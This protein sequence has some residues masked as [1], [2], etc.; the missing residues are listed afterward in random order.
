MPNVPAPGDNTEDS[1]ASE[2]APRSPPRAAPTHVFVVIDGLDECLP[3]EKSAIVSTFRALAS[4]DSQTPLGEEDESEA[5]PSALRCLFVSQEDA[6][7]AKLLRDITV[8]RIRPEDNVGDIRIFCR[9]WEDIIRGSHEAAEIE[10]GS[11]A[12]KGANCPTVRLP[13]T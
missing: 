1:R 4:L 12:D 5:E 6:E 9:H 2:E 13:P 3:K 8:V 10:A 11:I 7:C